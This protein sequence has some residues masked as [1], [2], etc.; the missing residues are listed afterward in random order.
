M[1]KEKLILRKQQFRSNDNYYRVRVDGDV[2]EAIQDL[3]QRTNQSLTEIASKMLRFA[4]ERTEVE[5]DEGR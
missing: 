1:I 3:S 4:M 2:Y 5:G